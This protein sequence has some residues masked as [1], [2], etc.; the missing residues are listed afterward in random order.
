MWKAGY[1]TL[2]KIEICVQLFW[3]ILP[4][5]FLE[6]SKF[7]LSLGGQL[8][9]WQPACKRIGNIP[10]ARFFYPNQT[11]QMHLVKRMHL[12]L[13]N[14]KKVTSRRTQQHSGS[15]PHSRPHRQVCQQRRGEGQGRWADTP[16]HCCRDSSWSWASGSFSCQGQWGSSSQ[17]G[18]VAAVCVPTLTQPGLRGWQ[19]PCQG[20][21]THTRDTHS[22]QDWEQYSVFLTNFP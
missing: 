22:H 15:W 4:L 17:A 20:L 10:H 21:G 14:Q 8:G 11:L 13:R 12:M 2:S 6:G 7:H 16:W 1:F 18:L 9:Y 3:N 19:G 5:C